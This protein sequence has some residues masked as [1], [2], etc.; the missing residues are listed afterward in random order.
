MLKVLCG[1]YEIL[2]PLY[3]LQSLP[4][5]QQTAIAELAAIYIVCDDFKPR[6]NARILLLLLRF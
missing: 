1:V 3:P 2:Q 4:V 5:R 6:R